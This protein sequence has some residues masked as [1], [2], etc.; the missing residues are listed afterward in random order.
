MSLRYLS[1]SF[2]VAK[3]GWGIGIETGIGA[4]ILCCN[5]ILG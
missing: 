4:G 1:P 3:L 5:G 2:Y